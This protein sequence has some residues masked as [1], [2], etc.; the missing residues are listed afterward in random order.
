MPVK[1]DRMRFTLP[2]ISLDPDATYLVLRYR[3]TPET[4]KQVLEKLVSLGV[5]IKEVLF[6]AEDTEVGALLLIRPPKN[7]SSE[8][9]EA[10]IRGVEGVAEARTGGQKFGGAVFPP[11]GLEWRVAEPLTASI[12]THLFINMVTQGLIDAVGEAYYGFWYHA[13]FYAGKLAVQNLSSML[14]VKDPVQLLKAMLTFVEKMGWVEE[15]SLV[16]FDPGKGNLMASAKGN[17]EVKYKRTD[18]PV[19]Y[20]S[21]GLLAGIVSEI[22]GREIH[23]K[24]IRCQARGDP[25]CLF[26]SV[27]YHRR[28][29]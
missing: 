22:T 28:R 23:I 8:K 16:E 15:W 11:V 12:W 20:L 25:E 1:K 17:Q 29:S 26:V 13:G 9:L 24:E 7:L 19:C 6:E 3:N 4:Q 2:I 21:A 27:Q 5:E 10:E 18:K 14:R